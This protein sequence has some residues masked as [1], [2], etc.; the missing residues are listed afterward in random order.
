MRWSP[1][2]ASRA[3]ESPEGLQ[4]QV[5]HLF[6]AFVEVSG[7]L[8]VHRKF[9][10]LTLKSF[11]IPWLFQNMKSFSDIVC[12]FPENVK[13]FFKS[14]RTVTHF[15]ILTKMQMH[16][17]NS[18]TKW[19]ESEI[20][21]VLSYRQRFPGL[22]TFRVRRQISFSFPARKVMIPKAS[23]YSQIVWVR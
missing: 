5:K 11:K 14:T 19:L 10:F 1:E 13:T 9:I 23:D 4:S 15:T 8:A 6:F 2:N 7:K 12:L 16:W 22:V 21:P 20:S 17:Y 18:A 3:L